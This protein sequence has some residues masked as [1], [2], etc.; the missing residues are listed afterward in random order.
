MLAGFSV[1]SVVT[2]S[3]FIKKREKLLSKR[4]KKRE[5]RLELLLNKSEFLLYLGGKKS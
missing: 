1:F 3:L 2:H 5:K 4:E